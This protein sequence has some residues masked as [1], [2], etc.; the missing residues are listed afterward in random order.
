M[1]TGMAGASHVNNLIVGISIFDYMLDS[2][3]H[4]RAR[5]A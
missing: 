1:P 4:T 5:V 2:S 3:P